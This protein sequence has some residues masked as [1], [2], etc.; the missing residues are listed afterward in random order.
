MLD[1]IDTRPELIKK[2]SEILFI[3]PKKEPPTPSKSPMKET[4]P[5]PKKAIPV[6]NGP[7]QSSLF[8][9]VKKREEKKEEKEVTLSQK[10]TG[11]KIEAVNEIKTR[12]DSS[13]SK[14]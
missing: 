1:F 11:K 9:F 6:V 8:N 12:K 2:E 14:V 3:A 7:K 4:K 5:M 13:Q 10:S